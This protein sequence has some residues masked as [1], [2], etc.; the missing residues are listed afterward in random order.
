M[1]ARSFAVACLSFSVSAFW[2]A[3]YACGASSALIGPFKYDP[4]AHASPQ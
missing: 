1:K 4:H 3:A 2:I